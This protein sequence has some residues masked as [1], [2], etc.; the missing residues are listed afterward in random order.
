MPRR[1]KYISKKVTEKKVSKRIVQKK[2]VQKKVIGKKHSIIDDK[3][4]ALKTITK[5]FS[6]MKKSDRGYDRII[7]RKKDLEKELKRLG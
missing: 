1:K 6:G 7:K 4:E 3:K 5:V 2:V